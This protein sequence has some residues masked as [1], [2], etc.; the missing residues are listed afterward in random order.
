MVRRNYCLVCA[1][2][3]EPEVVVALGGGKALDGVCVREGT[4]SWQCV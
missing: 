2:G 4:S 3:L 1:N